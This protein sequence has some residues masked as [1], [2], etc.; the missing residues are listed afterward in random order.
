MK[1]L[2]VGTPGKERPALLDAGG[3]IRDLSSVIND[4]AG[5]APQARSHLING[6]NERSE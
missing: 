3:V 6:A 2:R 5:D 4:I 1:L